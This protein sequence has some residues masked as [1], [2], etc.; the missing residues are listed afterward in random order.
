M[1]ALMNQDTPLLEFDMIEQI[2]DYA[3][4]ET[5]RFSDKLPFGFTDI[6]TWVNERNYD[7]FTIYTRKIGPQSVS[8]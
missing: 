3:C 2:G 5:K 6:N 1:Y 7:H 8:R 4:I